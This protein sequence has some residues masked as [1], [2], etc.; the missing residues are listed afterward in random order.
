M[1]SVGNSSILLENRFVHLLA[2]G[3]YIS[4]ATLLF[5]KHKKWSTVVLWYSACD[6]TIFTDTY[7]Y[8][9]DCKVIQK[10]PIFSLGFSIM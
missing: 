7:S 6:T 1:G 8:K 3:F 10:F 4:M 9:M 2:Y 5:F